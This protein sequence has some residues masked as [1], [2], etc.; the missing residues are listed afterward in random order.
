MRR[1]VE[2]THLALT[3]SNNS[4]NGLVVDADDCVVDGANN[5]DNVIGKKNSNTFLF[6]TQWV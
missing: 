2:S 4:G 3:I 1:P 5:D 6:I